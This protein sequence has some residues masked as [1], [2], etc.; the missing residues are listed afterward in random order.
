ALIT[1]PKILFLDEPTLGLD[2]V[3]RRELWKIIE[4]LKGKMT[5]IVTTHYLEESE[6]LADRI[7]IMKDG[8]LKAMGTLEELQ[9]LSGEEK[10]EEIFLKISEQA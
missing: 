9:K 6:H 4:G 5:I 8:N 3:A 7:V 2:V 10:L 1:E